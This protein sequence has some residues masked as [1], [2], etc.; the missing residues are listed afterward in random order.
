MS[1]LKVIDFAELLYLSLIDHLR[2]RLN[3]DLNFSPQLEKHHKISNI[4][5]FRCEML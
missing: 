2:N 1:C 3:F 4:P 5:K